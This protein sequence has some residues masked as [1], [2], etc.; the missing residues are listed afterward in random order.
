MRTKS[1]PTRKEGGGVYNDEENCISQL[2]LCTK[3]IKVIRFRKII[4][5]GSL[6]LMGKGEVIIE[7][8]SESIKAGDSQ[9]HKERIGG[10]I[11]LSI[12]ETR[13][14]GVDT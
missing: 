8:W 12:R 14:K 7:L 10:Y 9:S 1:G 11:D 2:P 13:F 5:T 6:V 4:W 3:Y